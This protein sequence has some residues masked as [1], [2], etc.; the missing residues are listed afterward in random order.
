MN[1]I[2]ADWQEIYTAPRNVPVMTKID[3]HHGVRNEQVLVRGSARLW[4][5]PNTDMYVYYQPTHWK[6]LQTPKG[7]L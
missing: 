1:T 4:F 5:V 7:E 3:D 6:S 2:T